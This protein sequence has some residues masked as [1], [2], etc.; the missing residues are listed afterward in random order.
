MLL[1]TGCVHALESERKDLRLEGREVRGRK[2]EKRRPPSSERAIKSGIAVLRPS[3]KIVD[4]SFE[5]AE[6]RFLVPT[7]RV[8]GRLSL[9][10]ILAI[11]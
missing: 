5:R 1:P 10:V 3:S 7:L 2:S 6:E 4:P 11:S 9:H 8:Q